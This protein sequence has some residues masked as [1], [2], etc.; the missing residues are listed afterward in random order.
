M[1]TRMAEAG[2]LV[3]SVSTQK[4]WAWA[5][6]DDAIG[7][8]KTIVK[9]MAAFKTCSKLWQDWVISDHKKF[10]A[11]CKNKYHPALALA[12]LQKVDKVEQII[13]KLT[14]QTD[15]MKSMHQIKQENSK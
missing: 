11:N 6:T 1:L 8:L 3:N 14:K 13:K 2:D 10:S 5:D 12:E 9:E 4:E 7:R 15:M